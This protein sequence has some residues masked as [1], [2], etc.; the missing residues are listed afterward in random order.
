MRSMNSSKTE[1]WQAVAVVSAYRKQ[2]NKNY[3]L[4][5]GNN[6]EAV[7]RRAL[8]TPRQCRESSRYCPS[9][10]HGLLSYCDV[11]NFQASPFRSFFLPKC[12]TCIFGCFW[13]FLD[14]YGYSGYRT[15]IH[16]TTVSL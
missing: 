15:S 1:P 16:Q 2:K 6:R 10:L 3:I 7:P 13:I 14:A 4:D 5:G 8:S 12:Q 9:H 11:D